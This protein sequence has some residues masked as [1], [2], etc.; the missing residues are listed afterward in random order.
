MNSPIP[1]LP[2]PAW[3]LRRS[4]PRSRRRSR[5]F[6]MPA[7]EETPH[8]SPAATQSSLDEGDSNWTSSDPLDALLADCLMKSG[9]ERLQF[10]TE[11]EQ[12]RPQVAE[13]LRSRLQFLEGFG[14]D[15]VS[16]PG[17]IPDRLGDFVLE[18]RIGKG[19]M[20]VVYS[21]WEQSLARHVA[22]K[23][24]RP[25]RLFFPGARERFRREVET[26]AQ[27]QHPGIVPIYRVGEEQSIPYFAME[28]IP[29]CSLQDVIS[30][31]KKAD[32]SQLSG[33]DLAAAIHR[34][35]DLD[36]SHGDCEELHGTFEGTWVQSCF[37]IFQRVAEALEH[38]HR[39][40]VLH[41][42]LKPANVLVTCT[43]RVMLV[44]FGL[45]SSEENG[46]LTKTGAALG[47]VAYMP[48]EQV[49]GGTSELH[50]TGDVYSLG[51]SLYEL[52]T[53]QHPFLAK[54]SEATQKRI[55]ESRFSLPR[56]VNPSIPWDAE[57]VC[58]K[59]MDPDISRRYSSA[60]E[61]A[62]DLGNVLA[63]RPIRARRAGTLLRARRWTQRHPTW[64]VAAALGFFAV[65]VLPSVFWLQI[66]AE[67]HRTNEA[68]VAEAKERD[69][70][71]AAY[72]QVNRKLEEIQRLSDI[73][74]LDDLL[75]EEVRL[76]PAHPSQVAALESWI[77]RASDLLA[78]APLHQETARQ[79]RNPQASNNDDATTRAWQLAVL[80][81]FLEGAE[82]LPPLIQHVKERHSFAQHVEARTITSS[83]A[84][85]RW[86]M[87]ITDI[88]LSDQYDG[89]EIEPQMGLLP[90]EPDPV[91]GLW[92]FWYPQ[93]GD[94]PLRN[95]RTDRLEIQPNS[96]MVFVLL[97]GGEF[98]MGAEPPPAMFAKP[99]DEVA[100]ALETLEGPIHRVT[101]DP[102]FFS[103]YEMT[104]GQWL[105][106]FASNPSL[107]G[108]GPAAGASEEARLAHPLENVSYV[109]LVAKLVP[110]GLTL[111][112]EAQWEYG[113]RSGTRTR[114]WFG[115]KWT[116][117]ANRGNVSGHEFLNARLFGIAEPWDDGWTAHAP[118]GSFEPN[119][120][121]LFNL[122][123]NVSEWCLDSR[124]PYDVASHRHGDGYLTLDTPHGPGR[125]IRGGAFHMT[126]EYAR[127]ASRMGHAPDHR[128][129]NLGARPVIA[130]QGSF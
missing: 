28:R 74:I 72:E 46:S 17:E 52:L 36:G 15:Q 99:E 118:A 38:A 50:V 48:P 121:G 20:G 26:I 51:V 117:F 62:E 55:L 90:L 30:E 112:T 75:A 83:D 71:E 34:R 81:D 97:P 41:R 125:S 85:D 7:P 69:A 21:A 120:F 18:E 106:L 98:E 130:L 8:P 87:A 16:P 77:Q 86:D 47:S 103:K 64:S 57:T 123:G 104:Q 13:E 109:E 43:G 37:R 73:K 82:Q 65:V 59:A 119:D 27:L 126:A 4:L 89:L 70:K 53:L 61:F 96:G 101:L 128:A 40:G 29:G 6:H 42:D 95:V 23:L 11:L 9:A 31:L 84:V 91:S 115:E 116:E 39:Q 5:S 35:A 10:L 110:A 25:E 1:D 2:G 122:L 44:D 79:L 93:S 78:R 80:D 3:S 124:L 92:E 58:V 12:D 129:G 127:S 24:I 14:M 94:E 88:A 63:L 68:R 76:W 19:G 100:N 114:F 60:A 66:R 32:K 33:A 111:P 54:N 45:A 56:Q 113:C 108:P 22:L 105:R 67:M 49:R 102:F 107:H